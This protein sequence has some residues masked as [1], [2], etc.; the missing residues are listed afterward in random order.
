MHPAPTPRTAPVPLLGKLWASLAGPP[1]ILDQ[2]TITGE[3]ALPSVYRVTDLATAA[4]GAAGAAIAELIGLQTAAIPKVRLD[5][6]LASMWFASSL[7]PIGWE[8]PPV[9]HAVAGDYRAADTWIR[10]HANYPHHRQ[11]ALEVLGCPPER[12]AVEKAVATWQAEDLERAIVDSGGCAA[13]L[14]SRSDWTNHPQ[15]S[16]VAT[17]PVM[18]QTETGIGPAPTWQIPADRPLGGVRVLDLTRVLAGPV[19]T[20][21]LAGFGAHVLRVDPP[22]WEEPGIAP[23]MTVGK[24]C[25][26]LDLR[27]AEDRQQLARL[28]EAADVFVHGYRADALDRLGFGP[29]KLARLHPGLVDVSLNAYGWSGPW[30]NR[31]G[32]DSLVQ[33]SSGIADS[34]MRVAAREAPLSLPVQALDHATGYTMAAAVVR[35][36]VARHTSGTGWQVRTSLARTA[37][38][39]AQAGEGD[40]QDSPPPETDDDVLE[41]LETTAW[42]PARRL[43][44]PLQIDGTPFRWDRPASGLGSDT[45]MWD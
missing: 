19:A 41:A 11:I 45:P 1:A 4:I 29:D 35:G 34:G 28:L 31:R 25:A 32:F 44:P 36:L 12:C 2:L 18:H 15:G 39:L 8:V 5:R 30:R 16:A 24:R 42:G 21:F 33:M 23:E 26:R 27:N 10:L 14:R 9:W 20:R 37:E 38:L 3:G 17:E 6:R 22:G 7:R 13:M 43:T 40:L